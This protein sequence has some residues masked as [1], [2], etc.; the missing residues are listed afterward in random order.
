MSQ[1]EGHGQDWEGRGVWVRSEGY[2]SKGWVGAGDRG[3]G[4]RG[5]GMAW[6]S[7]GLQR[8][9]SGPKMLCR[10]DWMLQG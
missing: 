5:T 1:D 4:V 10:K 2:H 8:S 7:K 6:G 3:L 9:G